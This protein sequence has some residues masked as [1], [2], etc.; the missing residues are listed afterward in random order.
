M[1]DPNVEAAQDALQE[2][3]SRAPEDA[4]AQSVDVTDGGPEMVQFLTPEGERIET[5]LNAPYARYLESID[6][7]AIK[8]MYLSLIH[9]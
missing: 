5:E 6:A 4:G 7:E 3:A 9:I 2:S 8:A 1:S